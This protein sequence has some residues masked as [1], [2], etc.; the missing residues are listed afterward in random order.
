M[1]LVGRWVARVGSI[2]RETGPRTRLAAAGLAGLA[3][4]GL[5]WLVSAVR[6]GEAAWVPVAEAP[7]AAQN[8]AAAARTAEAHGIAHRTEGGRLLVP[9]DSRDRLRGQLAFKGLL[10]SDDLLPAQD[11]GESGGIWLTEA[12]RKRRREWAMMTALSRLIGN[13]PAVRRAAVLY[14]PG[15]QRPFRP[16][17]RPRASVTVTLAGGAKMGT[18]LLSAIGDL[19]SSSF[20]GMQRGDVCVVDDRGCSDRIPDGEGP[21]TYDPIEQRRLA[22]DFQRERILAA[23]EDVR[24][25]RAG[26]TLGDDGRA[27]SCR[28]AWV[29][30]PRSFVDARYR[31]AH[32]AEADDAGRAAFAAEELARIRRLVGNVSGVGDANAI[33]VHWRDDLAAAVA[34][35]PPGRAGALA[36]RA[37]GP[38]RTAASGG[39]AA[40]GL[41]CAVLGVARRRRRKAAEA[42]AAAGEPSPGAAASEAAPAAADPLEV[43]RRLSAEEL[44]ALLQGEHPQTVALILDH[45]EAGVAAAVLDALPA[46]RQVDISRRIAALGPVDPALVAEVIRGLTSRRAARPAAPAD[47]ADGVGKVAQILHHAGYAT[48]RAVLDGLSGAEPALAES[49]RKQMFVFED[50][51]LLPRQV[52]DSALASLGSDELAIALRTAGKEV[53]ERIFSGLPRERV[54]KVRQ[55]ME[56]IGPVRLSDVEAAQERVVA[57]VRRLEEGRYVSAG[58]R[59]DSEVL[60]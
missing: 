29:S 15:A 26:V 10:R 9:A 17:V 38:A 34:V 14:S 41:L 5:V 45:V 8:L 12:E 56:R 52:L 21:W 44:P 11:L 58:S 28:S 1:S 23:L 2:A 32:G 50:V 19:V 25:A 39:L 27:V 13:F 33:E 59:K 57:A 40:L 18:R 7:M 51:A 4:V 60:A 3:M 55:E 30:L 47:D 48:E 36:D 49:I 6:D 43:L 53:R 16:G 24:G 42:G 37:E 20:A 54:A 35:A 46:E 22:E 31:L